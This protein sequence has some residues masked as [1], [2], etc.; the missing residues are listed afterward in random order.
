MK[1]SQT[2]VLHEAKKYTAKTNLKFFFYFSVCKRSAFYSFL[3]V[4]IITSFVCQRVLVNSYIVEL[5]KALKNKAMTNFAFRNLTMKTVVEC[6]LACLDD[7]LCRSFQMCNET[8]CQL[9]SS[10][11]FQSTLVIMTECTY[12]DMH[13]TASQQVR[14]LIAFS[15]LNFSIS[16]FMNTSAYTFYSKVNS[17]I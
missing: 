14:T 3:A 12:Y 13:P 10:N 11:Q 16:I 15:V 9:L 2:R 5:N 17:I 8:E 4:V 1:C 6:F 7:C